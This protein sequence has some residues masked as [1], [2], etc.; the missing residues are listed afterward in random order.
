MYSV[1]FLGTLYL[2]HEVLPILSIL[3][4]T[5]QTGSLSYAHIKG[6]INYAKDQLHQLLEGAKKVAFL[7]DLISDLEEDPLSLTIT[8]LTQE[9]VKRLITLKV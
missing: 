8:N 4:K 1:Y 2:L 9:D 5:F 7:R 3:S 6:S